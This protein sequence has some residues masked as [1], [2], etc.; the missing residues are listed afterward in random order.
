RKRDGSFR[1]PFDP[2]ASG[3]G[4]DYTEGNAWQY[5]WYVPHDV[6][7][8]AAAHGGSDKLLARLDEVFEAKVDPAIFEH[9]E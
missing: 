7:G 4:T 3:Y 6:A 9:M 1:T 5:S 8:L 2:S